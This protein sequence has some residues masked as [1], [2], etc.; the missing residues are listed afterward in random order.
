[1]SFS[2]S[3]ISFFLVDCLYFLGHAWTLTY[4]I[5]YNFTTRISRLFRVHQTYNF[6]TTVVYD[7]KDI[8]SNVTCKGCTV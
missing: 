5:R 8:T 3:D 1:M 7:M 6:F 2:V 4:V